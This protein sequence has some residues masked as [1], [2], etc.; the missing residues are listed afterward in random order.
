MFDENLQISK[1]N[2]IFIKMNQLLYDSI[3]TIYFGT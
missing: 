1:D 3:L 2:I